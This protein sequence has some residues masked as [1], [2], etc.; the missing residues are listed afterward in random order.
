[1]PASTPDAQNASNVITILRAL[2]ALHPD[3]A[4]E[5]NRCV[6]RI[7]FRATYKKKADL[8]LVTER[9]RQGDTMVSEISWTTGLA[10]TQVY[11]LLRFLIA[12]NKVYTT[13]KPVESQKG[14]DR[15]TLLYWL[16]EK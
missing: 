2:A 12:R 14:G 4:C 9:L 10:P 16:R 3:I 8:M 6:T 15:K 5:L 1:M 7:R 11:S 13:R